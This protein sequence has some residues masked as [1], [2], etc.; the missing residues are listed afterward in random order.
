L[1]G[2]VY[3]G[4]RLCAHSRALWIAFQIVWRIKR[5]I[6]IVFAF[7]RILPPAFALTEL[8]VAA[9]DRDSEKPGA[10]RLAS[11]SVDCAIGIDESVLSCVGSVIR[12]PQQAVR[13]TVDWPLMFQDKSIEGVNVAITSSTEYR[14]VINVPGCGH[15][16]LNEFCTRKSALR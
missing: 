10:N 1:N 12:I 15:R 14:G 9:A 7:E 4:G 3:F 8:V 2:H 6:I 11:K 13:Q 5:V 16:V